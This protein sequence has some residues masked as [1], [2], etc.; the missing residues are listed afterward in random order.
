M[1]SLIN[2]DGKSVE[3]AGKVKISIAG[4]L[5]SK[6]SEELGAAKDAEATIMIK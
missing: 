6:R 4:S 5:P 2:D 3:A 1:L